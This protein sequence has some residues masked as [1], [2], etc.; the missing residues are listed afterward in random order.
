VTD[1]DDRGRLRRIGVFWLGALTVAAILLAVGVPQ[2]RE[3]Q[4][5][6]NRREA[7]SAMKLLVGAEQT[8]R[9]KDLDG[10][11][12]ADYWTADLATLGKYGLIPPD[13]AAAD[14]QPLVPRAGKPVP[15]HGYYFKALRMDNGETPPVAYRQ[16]TDPTSGK[17]H[18]LTKFGFVA[19][20]AE[21]DVTGDFA[22]IVNENNTIYPRPRF[23]KVLPPEEWEKLRFRYPDL[24]E[25]PADWPTDEELKGW[26]LIW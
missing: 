13:L 2:W 25:P 24:Q 17:V 6:V 15:Y 9:G 21:W 16:D 10:N 14:A 18:H 5:E 7:S 12:V 19:W 8:F 3:H 20:P 26:S 4:R 1:E 22:F 23:S 11:K